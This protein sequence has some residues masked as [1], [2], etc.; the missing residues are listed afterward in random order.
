MMLKEKNL[1]S[2]RKFFSPLIMPVSVLC[3][4]DNTVSLASKTASFFY[5]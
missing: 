2:Y 4:F 3:W 5:T 1:K